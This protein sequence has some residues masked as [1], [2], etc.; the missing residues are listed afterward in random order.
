MPRKVP[1][2]PE[3]EQ[4]IIAALEKDSQ[5]VAGGAHAR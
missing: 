5:R 2:T 1:I 3:K 4:E